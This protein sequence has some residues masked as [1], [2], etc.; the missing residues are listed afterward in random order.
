MQSC[1]LEKYKIRENIDN[2]LFRIYNIYMDS[3]IEE[4]DKARQLV[5]SVTNSEEQ[6]EYM[7]WR[8][9]GFSITEALGRSG[10]DVTSLADWYMN[11]ANF[12]KVD[13]Q[14]VFELRATLIE[15]ILRSKAIKNSRSLLELDDKV[16]QIALDQGLS[17]LTDNEVK[18]IEKLRPAYDR[19][20]GVRSMLGLDEG[21]QMPTTMVN[22][23]QLIQEQHNAVNTEESQKKPA[24]I[25]IQPDEHKESTG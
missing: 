12:M 16:L 21:E 9:C 4:L 13:Q 22:F 25:S 10:T 7:S 18:Y 15:D 19:N 14:Q 20:N 24:T 11:S 6:R 17:S 8:V 23:V 5:S 2:A 1:V 3:A